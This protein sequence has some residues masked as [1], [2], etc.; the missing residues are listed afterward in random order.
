MLEVKAA[1]VGDES[2]G[3]GFKRQPH[4][5]PY[6]LHF[7]IAPNGVRTRIKVSNELGTEFKYYDTLTKFNLDWKTV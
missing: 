1:F 6:F 2:R 7:E 5:E 4:D 3:N